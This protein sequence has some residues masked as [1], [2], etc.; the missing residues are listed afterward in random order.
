MLLTFET[1]LY[2]PS[3]LEYLKFRVREKRTD[4]NNQ[5]KPKRRQQSYNNLRLS[6]NW[7]QQMK[8]RLANKGLKTVLLLESNDDD[9]CLEYLARN[10]P[11]GE[12]EN[13]KRCQELLP[14]VDWAC[15]CVPITLNSWE[16]WAQM[17]TNVAW[18]LWKRGDYTMAQKMIT[19]ALAVRDSVLGP[20]DQQTL[21]SVEILAGVLS[22]QGN[23]SGAV[24][25]NRRALEG[26]KRTLGLLHPF[27]LTNI[28]NLALTLQRL[29][30]YEESEDLNRLVL[31]G[32]KKVLGPCHADTLTSMS[33]LALVLQHQG[34]YKELSMAFRRLL[35]SIILRHLLV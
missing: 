17:V 1:G 14:Y 4:L 21:L 9:P 28:S 34:K 22:S 11:T 12:F 20:N 19:E 15:N 32:S 2:I 30:S 35:E 16:A 29:G 18:Y 10:F 6:K 3:L 31:Q 25:L 26:F 7:F 27:T 24:G 13:W 5:I 33:N 8:N 23:H